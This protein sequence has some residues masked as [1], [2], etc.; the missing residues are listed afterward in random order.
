MRKSELIFY[1]FLDL[2]Q[3]IPIN[4]LEQAIRK[5]PK[6]SQE[7]SLRCIPTW[8]TQAKYKYEINEPIWTEMINNV[9]RIRPNVVDELDDMLL[10]ISGNCFSGSSFSLMAQQ[11]DAI[12]LAL[13]FA[14]IDQ[15]VLDYKL[16][17]TQKGQKP[18]N[19]LKFIKSSEDS[20]IFH[21]LNTFLFKNW[22]EDNNKQQPNVRTFKQGKKRLTVTNVNRSKE[23]EGTLGVDLLFYN[24]EFKLFV[25]VQYKVWQQDKNG[26]YY[27]ADNQYDKD[28]ERMSNAEH[29]YFNSQEDFGIESFRLSP[30]PFYFK[31]CH[32]TQLNYQNEII[33]GSYIAYR[34]LHRFMNKKMGIKGGRI[35]REKEIIHNINHEMFINLVKNGLIGSIGISEFQLDE[36]VES[37]LNAGNSVTLAETSLVS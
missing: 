27:R 16:P 24:Q 19:F 7:F 34:Y 37:L 28:I 31:L 6:A 36:I 23:Y 14:G 4:E 30:R 10:E 22:I 26:Y 2:I 11:K 33:N 35:I 18:D 17:N 25:M 20:L 9:K 5:S 15:D 8:E 21:D 29:K 13:N 3:P 1:R 32:S 12:Q